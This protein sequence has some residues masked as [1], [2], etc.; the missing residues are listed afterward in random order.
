MS[1]KKKE[2]L[3]KSE[4]LVGFFLKKLF[5]DNLIDSD[6]YVFAKNSVRK[7]LKKN[8]TKK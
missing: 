3:V 7:D 2:K 1:E 8:V 6:T 5:E 4:V